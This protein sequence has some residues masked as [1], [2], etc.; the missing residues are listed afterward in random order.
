MEPT[1]IY[2]GKKCNSFPFIDFFRGEGICCWAECVYVAGS[3]FMSVF[4]LVYVQHVTSL[5]F[6]SLKVSKL[7][8]RTWLHVCPFRLSSFCVHTLCTCFSCRGSSGVWGLIGFYQIDHEVRYIQRGGKHD[9]Q[10][11]QSVSATKKPETNNVSVWH[12]Q[13]FSLLYTQT[14]KHTGWRV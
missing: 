10:L 13:L 2:P 5:V 12:S 1:E 7:S 11:D 14:Q 6:E 8:V 9:L 4:M 3:Y